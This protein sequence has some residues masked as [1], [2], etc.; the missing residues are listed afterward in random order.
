VSRRVVIADDPS[1]RPNIAVLEDLG[2]RLRRGR[3]LIRSM[4]TRRD[5]HELVD[6]EPL[7]TAWFENPVVDLEP[8]ARQS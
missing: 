2:E 8:L 3:N 4:V 5:E 7:A 1:S 6:L